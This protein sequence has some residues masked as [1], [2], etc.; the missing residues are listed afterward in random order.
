MNG[1]L[2]HPMSAKHRLNVWRIADKCPV[3]GLERGYSQANC[4]GLELNCS[5][6]EH[7]AFT[8]FFPTSFIHQSGY[9][10]VRFEVLDHDNN[11]REGWIYKMTLLDKLAA[12]SRRKKYGKRKVLYPDAKQEVRQ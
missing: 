12:N 6:L 8:E 5:D 11:V 9:D 7:C 10:D 2:L 1:E 3:C 4:G